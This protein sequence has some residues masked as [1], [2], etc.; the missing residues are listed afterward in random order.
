MREQR[1]TKVFSKMEKLYSRERYL[2]GVRK[3][4]KY[5]EL[6]SIVHTGN[7]SLLDGLRNIQTCGM[8]LTLA[9]VLHCLSVT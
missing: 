8:T 3:F 2:E 7:E 1:K 4:E 9:Y 6:S 5:D